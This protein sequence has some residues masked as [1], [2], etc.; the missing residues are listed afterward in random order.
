MQSQYGRQELR[1]RLKQRRARKRCAETM[2]KGWAVLRKDV[3]CDLYDSAKIG[4]AGAD[5]DEET[6]VRSAVKICLGECIMEAFGEHLPE[7][8]C[9]M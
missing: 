1:E 7:A 2:K 6:D 4:S 8:R 5:D 9:P 3:E